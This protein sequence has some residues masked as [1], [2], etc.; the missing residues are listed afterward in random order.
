MQIPEPC[1]AKP[2]LMAV[3]MGFEFRVQVNRQ[4]WFGDLV[5]SQLPV[6]RRSL[7]QRFRFG[8]GQVDEFAAERLH[9]TA[10][11]RHPCVAPYVESQDVHTTGACP[12]A[13]GIVELLGRQVEEGG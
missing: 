8:D 1:I 6:G 2:P 3:G 12:G 10:A 13:C 9:P 7:S 11:V 4:V 5:E